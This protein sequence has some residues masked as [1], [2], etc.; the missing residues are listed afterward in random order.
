MIIHDTDLTGAIDLIAAYLGLPAAELRGYAQEDPYPR[1]GWDNDKGEAPVGSLFSV[2][3]RIL[4]AIVRAMQPAFLLEMGTCVGASTV[5]LAAACA[6]TGRGRI[7]SVDSKVQLSQGWKVGQLIPAGLGSAVSLVTS[8]GVGFIKTQ[9]RA[10]FVFEDMMHSTPEVHAVWREAIRILT[11]GG[12]II[13]HDAAH[14][15][16]GHE[17]RDGIAAALAEAG[18]TDEPLVL[19]IAPGDTGMAIWR[20][21]G[22]QATKPAEEE[23]WWQESSVTPEDVRAEFPEQTATTE[24]PSSARSGAKKRGGKGL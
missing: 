1:M 16:V 7:I 11:P 6:A 10:D 5:H 15:I 8:E 21:P 3:G 4:Y 18:I 22:E 23:S 20:K 13:S 19:K 14:F 12:V 2:E 9:K 24:K 17:V